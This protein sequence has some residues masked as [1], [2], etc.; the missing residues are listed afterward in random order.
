MFP[1]KIG[2]NGPQKVLGKV[3]E[4]TK[5]T[6]LLR[7]CPFGNSVIFLSLPLSNTMRYNINLSPSKLEQLADARGKWR[8]VLDE[9]EDG[10]T[11]MFTNSP[12][13]G[14]YGIGPDS[15][16]FQS[17]PNKRQPIKKRI[18]E[19]ETQLRNQVKRFK[20]EKPSVPKLDLE[21]YLA[22]ERRWPKFSDA[23]AETHSS[24]PER[25]KRSLM[26]DKIIINTN[27]CNF[28]SINNN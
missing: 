28:E 7:L 8:Q 17:N 18:F 14:P 21:T 6:N 2:P 11:S 12:R 4:F 9:R 20:V 1:F 23:R 13:D 5:D 3:E 15:P 25:I 27:I 24:S 26:Y 19:P 16:L 22:L 10:D